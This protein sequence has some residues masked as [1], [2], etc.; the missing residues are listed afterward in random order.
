MMTGVAE[1]SHLK[2]L[3]ENK[4]NQLEMEGDFETSKHISLD[5]FPPARQHLLSLSK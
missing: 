2:L 5:S 4:E 1:T 3:A